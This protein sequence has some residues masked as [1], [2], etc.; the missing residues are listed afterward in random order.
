MKT[1][2]IISAAV[3]TVIALSPVFAFAEALV[4]TASPIVPATTSI[5]YNGTCAKTEF[6]RHAGVISAKRDSMETQMKALE[7]KKITAVGEAYLLTDETAR[8]ETMKS[9]EKTFSEG[10]KALKGDKDANKTEIELH[11]KNMTECGVNKGFNKGM[12]KSFM[13]DMKKMFKGDKNDG[14]MKGARE[15]GKGGY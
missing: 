11:K 6:L 10:V 15:G 14:E 8:K 9:A 3:G 2:K 12:K 4:V 7:T 5:A 13:N 1:N